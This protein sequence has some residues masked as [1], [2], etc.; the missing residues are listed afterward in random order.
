M[1][2]I[3]SRFLEKIIVKLEIFEGHRNKEFSQKLETRIK[4]ALFLIFLSEKWSQ[5]R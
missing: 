5:E 1:F 3:I 2:G 4:K